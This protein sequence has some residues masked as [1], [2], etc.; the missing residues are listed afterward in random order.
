M[1][2]VT[3]SGYCGTLLLGYTAHKTITVK[4]TTS[5]PTITPAGRPDAQKMP[6]PHCGKPYRTLV[7]RDYGIKMEGDIQQSVPKRSLW[8]CM[9]CGRTFTTDN[10]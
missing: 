9:A 3:H 2:A 10:E 4:R 6:C 1:E 8:R 7:K 5:M